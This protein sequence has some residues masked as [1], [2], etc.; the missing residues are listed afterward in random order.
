[1]S[2]PQAER[3]TS[4]LSELSEVSGLSPERTTTTQSGAYS[5]VSEYEEARDDFNEALAPPP[6]F[7]S[8]DVGAARKGS[9]TRD[10]KFR[11]VGI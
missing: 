10:S 6:V 4:G 3:T 11:E 8:T 5:D 2:A 9:P 7:T 1:M